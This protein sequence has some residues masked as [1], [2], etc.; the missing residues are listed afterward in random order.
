MV[1]FFRSCRVAQTSAESP[2]QRKTM[3]EDDIH[4][5]RS[6]GIARFGISRKTSLLHSFLLE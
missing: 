1:C 4:R 5:V 6:T 2:T 3:T